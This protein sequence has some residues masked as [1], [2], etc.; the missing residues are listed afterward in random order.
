MD[1]FA[2]QVNGW[3]GNLGNREQRENIDSGVHRKCDP[4]DDAH[5]NVDVD[6]RC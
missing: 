4:N 3:L 2:V 1:E 5:R 6:V